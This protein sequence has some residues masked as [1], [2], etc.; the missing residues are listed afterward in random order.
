MQAENVM[1]KILCDNVIEQNIR[2]MYY[3]KHAERGHF[4]GL[5]FIGN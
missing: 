5:K 4:K 2:G 1:S 3:T